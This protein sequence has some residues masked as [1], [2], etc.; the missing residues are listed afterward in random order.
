MP[1]SNAIEL[2]MKNFFA[3][4]SE[5]DRRRYAAVE[6]SKLGHGGQ[7]YIAQ[8]FGIDPKTVR[9]GLEDLEQLPD[10][11]PERVR[12]KGVDAGAAST[13]SPTSNRPSSTS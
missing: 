13:S 10:D 6:A 9:R 8:L 5:K 1:Y 12:K 7:E 3:S 4:L 11:H 2:Q